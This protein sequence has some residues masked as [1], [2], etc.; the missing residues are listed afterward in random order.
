MGWNK[1][2]QARCPALPLVIEVAFHW[3]HVMVAV[4]SH[5]VMVP[6]SVVVVMLLVLVVVMVVQVASLVVVQVVSCGYCCW[7]R[8]TRPARKADIGTNLVR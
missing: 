8:Q 4:L 6:V 1:A 3:R 5:A 2:R 7:V